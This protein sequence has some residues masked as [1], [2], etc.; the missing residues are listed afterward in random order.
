MGTTPRFFFFFCSAR[1]FSPDFFAFCFLFAVISR[2]FTVGQQIGSL[3]V[4]L[5]DVNNKE[6]PASEFFKGKKVKTHSI[7]HSNSK[8]KKNQQVVLFGVPGAFTHVC[9]QQHV[10]Q[11]HLNSL[12]LQKRFFFSSS[13]SHFLLHL[14]S[15]LPG[16]V[17]L[18]D[19]FK[20]KG[21][22]VACV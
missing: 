22:T 2:N 3:K 7:L 19:K 13:F 1:F 10:R 15:Q 9:S 14:F 5:R 6:F 4:N 8:K 20:E 12:S 11:H 21:Y 16:F 18:A 17:K